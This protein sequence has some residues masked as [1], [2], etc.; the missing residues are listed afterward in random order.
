MHCCSYSTVSYRSTLDS[1]LH[2]QKLSHT[3]H[4]ACL[5][6]LDGE[7]KYGVWCSV[8]WFGVH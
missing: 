3:A 4:T 8:V 7:K 2:P 5:S 1:S 6:T